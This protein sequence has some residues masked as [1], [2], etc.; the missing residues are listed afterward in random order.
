MKNGEDKAPSQL[1]VEPKTGWITVNRECNMRCAFCYAKGT[2]YDKSDEI[3][4]EFAITLVDSMKETGVKKVILIGGEPTL[5]NGLF[6]FNSYA[7]SIGISTTLVT[8][9]TR[10][11]VDKFWHQYLDSPCDHTSLSIKAYDEESYKCVTG[12][13]NFAQTKLGISRVLSLNISA[14]ASV[15]YTGEDVSELLNLAKFAREC[16]ATGLTISPGTPAYVGGRPESGKVSHPQLFV[17][18]FVECYESVQ[19]IFNGKISLSVK[20]P[21]CMWPRDFILNM[22]AKDQIYSTCQLQHRSGIIFDTHGS[23]L[24]CNSLPDHPI[25]KWGD[26]FEDSNSLGKHLKSDS[27][28]KF[29]D[30]MNSYASEKCVSCSMK[31]KCGGGCPL[32]YGAFPADDL[33]KGWD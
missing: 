3:T 19:E 15:V 26:H 16:G 4:L 11:S 24:S 18:R 30:K 27:V 33:V 6:A 32:F 31:K 13:S 8:N 7:K 20:L 23:L 2:G 22:I 1:L 10:F 5:W 17:D 21:L 12:R 14:N 28:T 9:G 25:G 29:Y